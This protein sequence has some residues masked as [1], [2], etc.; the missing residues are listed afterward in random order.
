MTDRGLWVAG[1]RLAGNV[2][3]LMYQSLIWF[4]VLGDDAR[5]LRPP[6][7]SEEGER[8]AD[9]LVDRVRRD[10]ELGRDFLRGQM[11]VDEEEAIELTRGQSGD[12]GGHYVV[13]GRAVTRRLMRS[14]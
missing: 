7:D 14:V 3:R 8:L 2:R 12:S 9:A 5:R 1:F 10:M 4:F 13:R 11:L 6:L